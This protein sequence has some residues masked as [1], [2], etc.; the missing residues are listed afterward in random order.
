[1]CVWGVCVCSRAPVLYM[2]PRGRAYFCCVSK[3]REIM[4]FTA[5]LR[6]IDIAFLTLFPCSTFYFLPHKTLR[7]WTANCLWLELRGRVAL[8]LGATPLKAGEVF[9]HDRILCK[10]PH[11]A[12]L[13]G[14]E[15]EGKL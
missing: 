1:M 15:R 12:V 5:I 6:V 14:S 9:A 8:Q 3:R 10:V 4:Y 13:C 11:E 2:S 7:A